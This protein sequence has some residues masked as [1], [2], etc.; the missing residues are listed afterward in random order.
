MSRGDVEAYGRFVVVQRHKAIRVVFLSES[1][2]CRRVHVV[3]VVLRENGLGQRECGAD[4]RSLGSEGPLGNRHGPR[5]AA[6]CAR[7]R[8]LR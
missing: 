2:K 1:G 5:V 3:I 4:G 6:P 7:A 8:T